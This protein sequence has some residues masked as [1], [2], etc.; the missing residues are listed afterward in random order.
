MNFLMLY[1]VRPLTEGFL[2]SAALIGLSTA[3]VLLLNEE[4]SRVEGLPHLCIHEVFFEGEPA[5]G[6]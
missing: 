6:E 3:N 5:R 1:E 4:A 2:T